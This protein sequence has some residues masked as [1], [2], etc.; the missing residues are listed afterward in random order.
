M[1]VSAISNGI[2]SND[3]EIGRSS[4]Q[5]IYTHYKLLTEKDIVELVPSIIYYLWKLPKFPVQKDFV[6][7]LLGNTDE[8]MR[9][10]LFKYLIETW[11]DIQLVRMDKF[12]YLIRK[13]LEYYPSDIDTMLYLFNV[14]HNL[15]IR[16][17]IVR[18]VVERLADIDAETEEFLAEFTSGCPP[19]L[20]LSLRSLRFS[21]ETVMKHAKKKNTNKRNRIALY[22]MIK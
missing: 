18:C 11:D 15:G 14:T 3:E 22:S 10:A 8:V 17:F 7:E 9:R 4:I 19:A 12:Y 16:T 5:T 2:R 6:L 20:L 13:I 21:K 1:D